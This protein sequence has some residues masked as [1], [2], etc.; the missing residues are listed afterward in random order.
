MMESIMHYPITFS[1][2]KRKL[3]EVIDDLKSCKVRAVMLKDNS[4][5]LQLIV[6]IVL[7]LIIFGVIFFNSTNQIDFYS[8]M[9]YTLLI[10]LI[11][12]I[13][14]CLSDYF[15]FLKN[16]QYVYEQSIRERELMKD[17]LKRTNVSLINSEL[18]KQEQIELVINYYAKE[19]NTYTYR[20]LGEIIFLLITLLCINQLLFFFNLMLF[21]GMF[22]YDGLYV[23]GSATQAFSDT[24]LLLSCIKEFNKEDPKKCKKYILENKKKE[25]RNL[26]ELYKLVLID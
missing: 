9:V 12:F 18:T 23:R 14:Y 1:S 11:T 20:Y 15:W 10:V 17:L 6:F 25:I 19:I 3:I 13:V 2:I 16:K 21:F 22:V 8:R 7:S 4:T 24:I 5:K 26:K